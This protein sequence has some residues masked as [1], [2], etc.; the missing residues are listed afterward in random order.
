M[1]SAV[2]SCLFQMEKETLQV[3]VL[4]LCKEVFESQLCCDIARRLNGCCVFYASISS[5]A[6]IREALEHICP[7]RSRNRDRYRWQGNCS[8]ET[9][10]SSLLKLFCGSALTQSYFVTL[11]KRSQKRRRYILGQRPHAEK[12]FWDKLFVFRRGVYKAL[13]DFSTECT[14]SGGAVRRRDGS[15]RL[16]TTLL[17][18]CRETRWTLK[19][20]KDKF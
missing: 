8:F 6:F 15:N 12:L 19:I 17:F 2:I 5:L 14:F 10:T 20:L 3:I 18:Y 7:S 4:Y 1:H 11:K 16:I 13:L 9:D